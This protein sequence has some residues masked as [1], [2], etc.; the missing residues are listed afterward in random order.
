M[1][2][3]TYGI[4]AAEVVDEIARLAA[5]NADPDTD[6]ISAW[7]TQYAARL[8]VAWQGVGASPSGWT[9]DDEEY[10]ASRGVVIG[11]VVAAWRSANTEMLDDHTRQL[12]DD[13]RQLI[14]DIRQRP[15]HVTDDH[16]R[17]PVTSASSASASTRTK[18]VNGASWF[19]PDQGFN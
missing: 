5:A 15:G 13:Y 8:N 9:T 18:S 17:L 10:H 2:V 7:V 1:A 12:I 6:Q 4:T 16:T 11:R 3:T 14:D 19:G